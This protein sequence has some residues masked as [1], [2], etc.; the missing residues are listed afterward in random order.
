MLKSFLFMGL[1]KIMKGECPQ[2]SKTLFQFDNIKD[3]K[4]CKV[5]SVF[6]HIALIHTVLE[7]IN[8]KWQKP[9]I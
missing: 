4:C 1:I 7:L 8:L 6:I 9:I 2:A 3:L 5:K